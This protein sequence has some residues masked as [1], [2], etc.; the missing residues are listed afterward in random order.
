MSRFSKSRA[1]L[2]SVMLI[3]SSLATTTGAAAAPLPCVQRAIDWNAASSLNYVTVAVTALHEIGEGA[4]LA[5]GALVNN[6]CTGP[7][8]YGAVDCLTS[9]QP[10]NALLLH[11]W[12]ATQNPSDVLRLTVNIPANTIAQAYIRQPHAVY[13][14]EPAC[15]G[16][17]VIGNDQFGNHWTAALTLGQSSVIH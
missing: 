15:I 13:E 1:S 14:F 2:V 7:A 12:L 3:G 10:R 17:L 9:F 8:Y 16:N 11:P 6:R 4:Y 5:G